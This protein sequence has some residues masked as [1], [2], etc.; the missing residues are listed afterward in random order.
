MT[1]GMSP[2]II[3]FI[4]GI[5]FTIARYWGEVK[6]LFFGISKKMKGKTRKFLTDSQDC[7]RFHTQGLMLDIVICSVTR[8]ISERGD[9][10]RLNHRCVCE[11]AVHQGRIVFF[12][13]LRGKEICRRSGLETTI[14]PFFCAVRNLKRPV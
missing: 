7:D 14:L 10:G 13:P 12:H 1:S 6:V 5:N 2:Y 9:V 4:A 8:K 11:F 3:Q